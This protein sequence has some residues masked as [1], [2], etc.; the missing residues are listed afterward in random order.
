MPGT[1]K[2]R[3]AAI[4]LTVAL[5]LEGGLFYSARSMER[6]PNPRALDL[7]P[8]DLPGWR[9]IKTGQVEAEEQ[10]I[11]KAD[12]LLTRWYAGTARPE[13]VSLFIAY[14]KSQRAGQAPHSPKNCLPG[15]GWEPVEVGYID[16]PIAGQPQPITIN[17]YIVANGDAARVV[18]YWYQSRNRVI[19]SDY[20][21][22]FWLVADSVRYHRSDTA[23]V[24][25]EVPI[26]GGNDKEATRMGVDFVQAMY[27]LLRAYLPS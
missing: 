16:V 23:I 25:V 17:R 8:M 6:V 1:R 2:G 12:D 15:S 22:K 4:V 19:A 27:P 10:E 21:A 7:F 3:K 26:V 24:R 18:L 9:T 5:L 11:L 20:A 13:T 14:F